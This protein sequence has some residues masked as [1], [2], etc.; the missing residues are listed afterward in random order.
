MGYWVFAF[1]GLLRGGRATREEWE[2]LPLLLRWGYA[3][4]SSLDPCCKEAQS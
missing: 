3:A 1:L 4:L 2:S